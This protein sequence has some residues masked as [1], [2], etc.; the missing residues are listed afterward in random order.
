NIVAKRGALFM[1]DL[2][3]DLQDGGYTVAHIKTDSIKIPEADAD[4]IEAIKMWGDGYGYEFDHE[5]TYDKF[6][7]VNDAV[8]IAKKGGDWIAVGSQ[9]Q[10]PYVFKSLFSGEPITFK[11]FCEDRSVLKGAMY[12]GKAEDDEENLDR[13][14]MRHIG[15]TGVFVPV[16]DGGRR[17][18]RVDGEK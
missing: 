5:T 8:Y 18:Y 13:H 3:H 1:I 9:F 6:C 7:L 10:D 11:D 15:R 14:S 12:L 4:V 17:L 16:F 2:K